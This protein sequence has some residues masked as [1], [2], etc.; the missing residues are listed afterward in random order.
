MHA[1]ARLDNMRDVLLHEHPSE[2]IADRVRLVVNLVC[3]GRQ[4][5]RRALQ[6]DDRQ[7]DESEE[8]GDECSRQ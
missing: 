6:L 8:S 4:V 7:E 1:V 3:C 5:R 2:C